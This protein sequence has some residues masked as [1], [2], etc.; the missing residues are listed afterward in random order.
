MASVHNISNTLPVY[1]VLMHLT[2]PI[3]R[4]TLLAWIRMVNQLLFLLGTHGKS[5]QDV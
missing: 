4:C 3:H 5:Q 2:W 1:M